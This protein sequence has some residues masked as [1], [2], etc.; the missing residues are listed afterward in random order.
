L[1]KKAREA[2]GLTYKH[3]GELLGVSKQQVI[4]WERKVNRPNNPSLIK[5]MAELLDLDYK[6]LILY[7]YYVED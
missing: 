2:K 1:L 5:W 7:F 4:N 6:E 3:L